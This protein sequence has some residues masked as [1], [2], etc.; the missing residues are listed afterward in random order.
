MN[1]LFSLKGK[2]ALIT[3]SSGGLGLTFARGLAEAG[4]IVIFNGRNRKK[5]ERA[6][7]QLRDAG[8]DVYVKAFDVTVEAQ[9]RAAVEDIEANIGAIDILVNN[10]GVQRRGSLETIERETFEEVLDTNLTAPFLMAKHVATR[11]MERRRGKIINICS[12]MSEL[13]RKTVGP[14]AASKGGLKMLT[15]AMAVDWAEYN[16][17]V[18]GIAPG[19]FITEM[20]QPLADDPEFDAWLKKRTPAGRWG[21]PD[22]LIGAAL[23]LAS[24]ASNFVNGQIIFVDGGIT[25][26]L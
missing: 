12:L 11:M 6:E 23:F 5:L 13:G 25:A 10:A 9:I 18:N 16:S 21:D 8:H 24:D 7:K 4:A 14:Y 3:G 22:E 17:Q 15:R 2:I 1:R 26:A 20:T 19:Y